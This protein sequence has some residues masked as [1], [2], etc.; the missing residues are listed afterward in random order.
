MTTTD[1]PTATQQTVDEL[2]G[3]LKHT[4]VQRGTSRYTD[5]TR[6]RCTARNQ[7]SHNTI[8]PQTVAQTHRTEGR[9]S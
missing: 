5:A 9:P 8:S 1:H 3:K 7:H 4:E 2:A 6:D